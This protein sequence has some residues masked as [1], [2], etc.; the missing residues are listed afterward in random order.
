MTIFERL[1]TWQPEILIAL[2]QRGLLNLYALSADIATVNIQ[3]L[4]RNACTYRRVRSRLR[5]ARGI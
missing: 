3:H 2:A 1:A 5:Q 4:M